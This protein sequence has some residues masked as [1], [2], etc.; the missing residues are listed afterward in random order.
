MPDGVLDQ[1]VEGRLQQRRIADDLALLGLHLPV[2]GRGRLPSQTGLFDQVRD[3]GGFGFQQMLK[4]GGG[5][6]K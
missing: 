2:S 1:R 6:Q 4:I 3:I 5:Q